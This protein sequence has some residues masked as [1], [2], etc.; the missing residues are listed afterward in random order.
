MSYYFY[1]I[2]THFDLSNVKLYA[3][4]HKHYQVCLFNYLDN[5][6]QNMGITIFWTL[7]EGKFKKKQVPEAGM[8]P[9]NE[10]PLMSYDEPYILQRM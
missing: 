1:Y 10:L 5:T 3:C 9:K 2:P 6:K 4:Y 7:L 8:G